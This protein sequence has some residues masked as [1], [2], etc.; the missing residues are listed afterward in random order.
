MITYQMTLPQEKKYL[1]MIQYFGYEYS[2]TEKSNIHLK[3]Y[4][5]V[6]GSKVFVVE[7]I[8]YS[9]GCMELVNKKY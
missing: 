6:G 5:Y 1:D 8:I 9:D 3:K 7:F 2:H 4:D